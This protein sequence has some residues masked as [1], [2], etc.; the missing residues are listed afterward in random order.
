MTRRCISCGQHFSYEETDVRWDYKG[1]NY[2]T[3]LINCKL[4]GKLNIL[5]YWCHKN[6]KDWEY[7]YAK[8]NTLSKNEKYDG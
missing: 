5:D 8:E 2:D 4:C 7:Q 6:R 1:S 3:K